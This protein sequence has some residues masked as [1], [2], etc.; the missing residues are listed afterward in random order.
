MKQHSS[1]CAALVAAAIAVLALG[2]CSKSG[3]PSASPPAQTKQAAEQLAANVHFHCCV[4]DGVFAVGEDGQAHFAE[5][6]ALTPEGLGEGVLV[7]VWKFE[8]PAPSWLGWPVLAVFG[9]TVS[10]V[11]PPGP[12][13]CSAFRGIAQST[14][15]K[16]PLAFPVGL[17]RGYRA[18]DTG[19]A[20]DTGSDLA[21]CLM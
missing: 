9:V 20:W 18:R 21:F 3:E 5:A 16:G 14:D 10:P 4:I 13:P 11:L 8:T 6:D 2:A 17:A 12:G 19:S 7:V 1:H 15:K